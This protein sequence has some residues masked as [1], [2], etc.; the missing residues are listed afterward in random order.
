MYDIANELAQVCL[1]IK[2]NPEPLCF[3]KECETI[4]I[5]FKR[6]WSYYKRA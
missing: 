3:L 1:P 2:E 5:V 6:S 4:L